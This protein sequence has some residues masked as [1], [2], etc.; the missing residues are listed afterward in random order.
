LLDLTALEDFAAALGLPE[1]FAD[2]E[3]CPTLRPE[4][5]GLVFFFGLGLGRFVGFDDRLGDLEE[6][7]AFL[8]GLGIPE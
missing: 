4:E 7:A 5:F 8:V 2:A 6:E 3:A 1:S